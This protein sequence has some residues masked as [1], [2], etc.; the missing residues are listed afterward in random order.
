MSDQLVAEAV[1]L[2]IHNK[3]IDEHPCPHRD[4]NPAIP[5]I[6]Q[7]KNSA[8]DYTPTEIGEQRFIGLKLL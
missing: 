3:H 5:A 8:L 2:T 1:R 7:P 4:S 6:K